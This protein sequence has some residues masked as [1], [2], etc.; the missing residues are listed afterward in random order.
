VR[1]VAVAVLAALIAAGCT[2]GDSGG[3]TASLDADGT[4]RFTDVASD[5]GLDFRHGAFRWDVTP[6]AAAMLGGGVCWIDFDGDG[7]LDLY[8][9]NSHAEREASRWRAEEGGLPRNALFHNVGGR[10]EDVSEGSGADLAERGTGCVAADLDLDGRTDL[11][12]TSDRSGTLLWNEGD[13]TFTDGTANAGVEAFGWYA[14]AAVGDV[15]GDGWPDLFLAGYANPTQDLPDAIQG[16]P[17]TQVAVRDLLYLSR[18]PGAGGRPTFREAGIDAGVE[19]V[20]PEYGLGA[21]LTDVDLDGDLDIYVANDT[22]P[23]RL[24]ANVAW[25]GG[26]AADPAGLGFRFEEV[27]ARAGV[28]DPGAGMGVAGADF[29]SDGHP[30]LIVTNARGEGHGVFRGQEPGQSFVDVRDD[31]GLDLDGSTGWGVSWADFDLDTDLDLVL[32]NGEIPVTDLSADVEPVEVFANQSAQGRNG[33]FEDASR[34]ALAGEAM[35]ARGSAAADYDNDGDLDVAVGTIGGSLALLENSGAAGNWLEV[36]FA[37]FCPGTRVT[38]VLADGRELVR[39]VRAGS[40]YLSSE[41]PRLHFGL[42][43]ATSVA[44]LLVEWPDGETTRLDEVDVNRV[45]TI[46]GPGAL[47]EV[48]R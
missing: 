15:N 25:P 3:E 44:R 45:L 35:V 30:D 16:F 12:V 1:R 26:V 29:D 37:Q 39:E 18:G 5:V 17:N 14:G 22:K 6:D 41:D 36:G 46:D 32:V 10:F 20:A 28:A 11:Y 24:Y 43:P 48:E 38:A 47:V 23:D 33:R 2:G 21:L 4:L 9:V 40:S 31:L 8:A 13:G 7:W 34:A 19:V 42:G 27:A